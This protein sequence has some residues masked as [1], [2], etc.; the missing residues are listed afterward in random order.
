MKRL[1]KTLDASRNRNAKSIEDQ[2]VA[3]QAADIHHYIAQDQNQPVVLTR[4]LPQHSDPAKDSGGEHD[5][6]GK[7]R[8]SKGDS[9]A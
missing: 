9:N 1:R 3:A 7:V 8:V 4:F 5:P 2:R 6:L